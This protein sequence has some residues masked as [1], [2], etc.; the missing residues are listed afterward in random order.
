[1]SYTIITDFDQQTPEWERF[2]TG[3][4]GGSSAAVLIS[5]NEPDPDRLCCP[6][7]GSMSISYRKTTDDYRCNSCKA[8]EII[9]VE[10]QHTARY[11]ELPA[12]AISMAYRKV[13]ERVTGPIDAPN[14]G[15]WAER[16]L[17]LEPLARKRYEEETFTSVTQVGYIAIGEWMGCSPDGLIMS[18]DVIEGG[19]EIKCLCA[20]KYLRFLD[21]RQIDSDYWFQCQWFLYITGAKWI[22][23]VMFHPDFKQDIAIER[24]T[25]DEKTHVK[26]DQRVPVLLDELERLAKVAGI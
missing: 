14:G 3:R 5:A 10:Y 8:S 26:W 20:D 13:G 1:M 17:D 9:P 23:F 22:D 25:W 21:T 19:I 18:G 24:V 12:G 4:V 2:T 11:K 15:Y 7:C 6:E 16:G